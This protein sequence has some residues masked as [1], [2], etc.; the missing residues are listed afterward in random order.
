MS[1]AHFT[2]PPVAPAAMYFWAMIMRITA[3][4]EDRTAVDIT[5]LQ[6]VSLV[7]MSVYR[8]SVTGR[9]VSPVVRVSAIRKSLHAK[10]NEKIAAVTREF[11]DTGRTIDQNARTC[12]QPS[13][14][15]ASTIEDGKLSR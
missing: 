9:M 2:A 15:A 5:A 7:P 6:S 14:R 4:R 8:P 13:T 11:F 3:G 12:P 1:D 10:R